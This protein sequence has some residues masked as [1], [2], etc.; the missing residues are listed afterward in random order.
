MTLL[1][2]GAVINSMPKIFRK[3]HK[4]LALALSAAMCVSLS[5]V[6]AFAAE[7]TEAVTSEDGRTTTITT[8]I[9]WASPEGEEPVVEGAAV[10]TE[11]TVL[12][13]EG[14]VIQESGSETGHETVTT[15]KVTSGTTVEDKE[16][17]TETAEGET[18]TT[19]APGE[20]ETVDSSAASSSEAVDPIFKDGDSSVTVELTP[21]STATGTAAVDKEALA[22]QLARPDAEDSEITDPGTGEGI[23]HRTVTV[24][25]VLDE[26]GAVVGFTATTTE[27][28][29]VTTALP[30]GVSGAEPPE[31]PQ[32]REPFTDADGVTTKVDVLPV[33]DGDGNLTGYQTTTTKTST[34]GAAVSETVLPD[35]PAEG[36]ATDPETGETTTV[37]V[38]ELRD[39]NGALT[40][41]E[42]TTTT[43]DR[44]GNV[45]TAVETLRGTKDTSTL[46]EVTDVTVT[47]VTFT[48][49]T[50]GTVTTT[51]RTTTT[52]T[53]RIAANDRTVT[54]EMG[55]VTVGGQDGILE[56]TGVKADVAEPDVGRTDQKTDLHHRADKDG[57]EFDPE[58]YDF[59]WLGKYG[60]ESA[61]RVDAVKVD[62]D[63]TASPSDR[64]QAHQFV[65]VDKDGNEHY[66]YCADF[67][68]SPQAGFRYDME[69]VE[70]AGYYDS[71]AAAHIRAIAQNGYWGISEGAGSLDAVKQMLVDAYNNGEIDKDDYRG[72]AT[73]WGFDT[74]LT[75]G[76][77]L[78][79]TQAALWTFGNSG[80]MMIDKE[81]LFT[82]YYQAVGGRNWR[83]LD[84]REW[85]LTK[86]LYDYLVSQTE[87][88][89]HQ[90]TLI[91]ENNFA[92]DASLT[93]GQRDE[94]TGKY[95]ADLTFTL[96]VMPDAE[97]DDLLVHVVVGGE[98]VETRRL[99][100]DDSGTQYGVIP[101]SGD[102]SY[103]LSGLKLAEGVNIDLRLTGTQNIGEG[104]YLFTSEVST[105]PVSYDGDG[106]PVFSS[107]TFVG[108]ESGRQSVDLSV[109]LNFTV[110]E[111]A[112]GVVTDTAS[113]TGRK[114]DATETS[115]TDTTTT[116]GGRTE[117]AVTVTT[118]QKNDR[119]WEVTWEKD[120]TYPDPEPE[121]P[122]EPET[123]DTPEQ[124]ETPETPESPEVPETTPVEPPVEDIP[125]EDV[126]QT[127]IPVED[128]PLV[129]IPDE[130]VPV[131]DVPQTG[132][133]SGLW[134]VLLMASFT[135][136]AVMGWLEIRD[137]KKTTVD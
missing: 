11:T 29:S 23:G 8:E 112:A 85:A 96:A 113:T 136:L 71:E 114:V 109:S 111:A 24:E 31:M 83:E 129:V 56:T 81:D 118:V 30:E 102:G 78:A 4:G 38:A 40:G 89:T 105:E 124:P 2:K 80:D 69:N 64:W 91:N 48:E 53:K 22:G 73:A 36:E 10:T 33:Y 3:F 67:A 28:T 127:D 68:V 100:G 135:G 16:P 6:P 130:E 50:G 132:D 79:A 101:R 74:Y 37:K 77:A 41:Y 75:D 134:Y 97:S 26:D 126:P 18:I 72:L 93:V 57:A 46:T 131:A 49:A 133:D 107:Q 106:E 70:D 47:T 84:S 34:T 12:D 21:G 66:V 76:M 87:A 108:V 59:Q 119:E 55:D 86:A 65:L 82:S 17:V 61:I 9:T 39:V 117:T 51:T 7:T 92:T 58:G 45:R 14:R 54:A 104:V 20:F 35:K 120:Y 32:P 123:P 60:L 19:E 98:V 125:E 90:N 122:E 44:E 25:D 121:T 115:R 94:D 99:A 42:V 27:E 1:W 5:S 63:G 52:E 116:T 62:G 103:T 128:V 137:R 15:E 13:E 95:E 88:P 43:T 110:N